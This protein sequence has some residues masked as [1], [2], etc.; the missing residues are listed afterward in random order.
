MHMQ[1]NP[2]AQAFRN[3]ALVY[4]DDLC[5]IY[6]YTQADGRYSRSSHDMDLDDDVQVVTTGVFYFSFCDLS[7]VALKC[8]WLVG[9]VVN[10]FG[11]ATSSKL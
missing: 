1:A 2:D 7:K 4:F 11:Y 6:G 5:L 10:P 3:R 8:I 9:F